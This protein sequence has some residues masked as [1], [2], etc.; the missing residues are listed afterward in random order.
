MEGGAL[1]VEVSGFSYVVRLSA[2]R[3]RRWAY[4][5]EAS[6]QMGFV[7]QGV[8]QLLAWCDSSTLNDMAC[9]AWSQI[10]SRFVRNF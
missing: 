8:C 7:R 3:L 2:R 4:V 6:A 1:S 5:S 10:K 9:R